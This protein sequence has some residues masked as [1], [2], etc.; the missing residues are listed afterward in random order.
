LVQPPG[1][2]PDPAPDVALQP[3][4]ENLLAHIGAQAFE[5]LPEPRPTFPVR[6]A[7]AVAFM[8]PCSG[9]YPLQLGRTL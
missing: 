7:A 6:Y 1:A 3:I 9:S 5:L 2:W 8:R 4:D